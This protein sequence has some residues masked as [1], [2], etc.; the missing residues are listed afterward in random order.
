[1]SNVNLSRYFRGKMRSNSCRIILIT[2]LIWLLIDVIVLMNYMD[3]LGSPKKEVAQGF[4]HV[5]ITDLILY[6]FYLIHVR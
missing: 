4:K 6:L 5:S 2:S 3:F 1:M